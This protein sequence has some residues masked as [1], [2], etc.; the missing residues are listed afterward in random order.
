MRKVTSILVLVV[1][2]AIGLPTLCAQTRPRRVGRAPG[3]RNE[4]PVER[5]VERPRNRSWTRILGTAISIGAGGGG[6]TPS[7]DIIRRRP[8]L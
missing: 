8:R 2:S 7:R 5:P 1:T 3:A 6:C 4:R